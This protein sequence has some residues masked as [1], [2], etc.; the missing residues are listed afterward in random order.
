MTRTLRT[1]LG[2]LSTTLLASCGV[3]ISGLLPVSPAPLGGGV[4]SVQP[5]LRW[6][7]LPI[8]LDPRVSEIVY[9]LRIL[10]A[11]GGPVYVREGLLK[12]EHSLETPLDP[13]RNYLWTVRA[14]FRWNGDRRM[15]Q[16]TAFSDPN[17]RLD[18]IPGSPT[19]YLPLRTPSLP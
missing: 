2:L 6:E 1:V 10:R 8:S 4:D 15:T 5:T 13:R 11:D 17:D 7:A 19:R 18:W 12:P 16:W 3:H 14:R 9:D